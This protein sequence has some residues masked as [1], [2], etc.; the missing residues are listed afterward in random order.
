MSAVRSLCFTQQSC[1]VHDRQHWSCAAR[2][3]TVTL[4]CQCSLCLCNSRLQRTRVGSSIR[5]FQVLSHENLHAHLIAVGAFD[6][7]QL[8]YGQR[9]RT[10]IWRLISLIAQ[11][12][13]NSH[14]FPSF[15]SSFF[16]SIIFFF[17][18][19]QTT[20]FF[21]LTNSSSKHRCW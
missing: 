8:S 21:S 18:C 19:R 1:T 10:N 13:K 15:F 2:T 3:M 5:F 9:N 16:L 20:P 11:S 6:T 4:N 7:E 14:V 17:A 12:D